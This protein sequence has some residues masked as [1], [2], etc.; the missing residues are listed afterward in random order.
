[1][2]TLTG[3]SKTYSKD[4]GRPALAGVSLSFQA[5]EMVAV[6]GPNGAGK[7]TLLGMLSGILAPTAGSVEGSPICS[8]VLQQTSLDKLLTVRENARVFA[9]VYG[10][11]SE[12]LA[13]RID[14]F[15][16]ALGLTERLDDRVGTLSGG[17]ARRAD[18]LRALMVGPELLL[19]DEPTAGLD[20]DSAPEIIAQ[21]RALRDRHGI[22]VVMVTHTMDEAEAA[23][24]V[25][26]LHDGR[27]VLDDA[28]SSL[29]APM[30]DQ[31]VLQTG[32]D[33]C[34]EKRLAGNRFL[35]QR[36]RIETLTRDLIDQDEHYSVRTVSIGDVYDRVLGNNT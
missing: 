13:V 1:M 27:V 2:I 3:V 17:L 32:A 8:V 12:R 6:L 9:S 31:L 26:I 25:L 21:I 33:L 4:A 30:R 36:D 14:E 18:L 34:E 19:L 28:P 29:L 11:S 5:G 15:A 35:V 16:K 10:V 24:R 22:A 20:R 23:D 7:S